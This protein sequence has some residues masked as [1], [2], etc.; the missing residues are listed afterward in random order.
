MQVEILHSP[1]RWSGW[2]QND[3]GGAEMVE[4]AV[5]RNDN[6]KTCHRE[7]QRRDLKQRTM[8]C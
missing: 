8:S 5:P 4:I 7:R 3:D 2:A 6:P 1:R